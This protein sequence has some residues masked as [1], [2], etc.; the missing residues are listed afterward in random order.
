MRPYTFYL[1]EHGHEA[2][3]FDFIHCSDQDQAQVHAQ[4]LLER[5]PEYDAV[6]IFDGASW[7]NRIDR[8]EQ[9]ELRPG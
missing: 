6:E 1:H 4:M 9:S 8:R 2:P 5:F 7:R 3:S